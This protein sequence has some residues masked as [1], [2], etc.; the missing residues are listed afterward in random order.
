[1][2]D[3]FRN[4]IINYRI[5]KHRRELY[6]LA[7]VIS[8]LSII[9][10]LGDRM[11]LSEFI[12]SRRAEHHDFCKQDSLLVLFR[13]D[14]FQLEEQQKLSIW[15]ETIRFKNWFRY[16]LTLFLSYIIPIACNNH[17]NYIWDISKLNDQTW[18]RNLER[19][20]WKYSKIPSE[21]IIII[22]LKLQNCIGMNNIE[23]I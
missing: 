15:I 2:A 13:I 22:I 9:S 23:T 17:K 12:L 20:F 21:D 3:V 1:M 11:A 18:N 16:L 6:L 19:V 10:S 8:W 14:R 4:P 7:Q 5:C